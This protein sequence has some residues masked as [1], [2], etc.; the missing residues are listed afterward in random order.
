M[1]ALINP[2]S[3]TKS[4][5]VY[6]EVVTEGTF[7]AGS[8]FYNMHPEFIPLTKDLNITQLIEIDHDTYISMLEQALE[9]PKLES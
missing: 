2:N 3:V 5:T 4:N 9:L 7:T 8:I 1:A 6:G